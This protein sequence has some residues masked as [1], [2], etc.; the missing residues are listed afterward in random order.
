MDAVNRLSLGKGKGC[1]ESPSFLSAP[2]GARLQART[3][4]RTG[5]L[6]GRRWGGVQVDAIADPS[7]KAICGPWLA[8]RE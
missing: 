6:S 1:A 8:G 2:A 7:G 5:D 3:L 4:S